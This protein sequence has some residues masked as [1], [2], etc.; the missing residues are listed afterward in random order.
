[1]SK[2][3][4]AKYTA[5][6]VD[7]FTPRTAMEEAARCL[8]CIDAPCSKGCPAGTDPGKFIRS[9]RF[10][11]IKGAAET[12]RENNILGGSC[13]RVCPYDRLC[14]EACSRCGIDRPIEIGKLQRFAVEQEKAHKMKIL[15]AP[16]KKKAD[17]VACIGSGPASLACAAK[18]AQA[19][20]QVTIFEA[21]EKAGGVLTYGI[22]P[23]RLPQHVVDFDIKA[24]KDL[25]VKFVFDT[26]VG[27][28]ITVEELKKADFKAIFVG[29]GLWEAKVPEIPGK[30]LKGVTNAIDFLKAARDSKGDFNPGKNVVVIGGGDVAMDCATTAKLLGAENVA[31]Y[32]R[33]TLEEA[34]ANMAEIQYATSLGVTITT[35][36]APAELVGDKNVEFAVFKGRDG[37]SSAKVAADTVVF[38]IGQAPEDMTKIAPVKVADK[39]TIAAN[40]KG[41]TNVAGIFAAGDI[42]NGGKTVVEAVAAGKEAAAEI[43]EY[44]EKKEGVK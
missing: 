44:L 22:T 12:I 9:I 25:G 33:R 29:A 11:N 34:P 6:A 10:R 8:L 3:V 17:K 40:A 16:S 43:I 28:D 37:A 20:Y 35:N 15:A 27:E 1:M 32:Y 38:A 21:A 23:A 19:G 42:V 18:L 36:F 2:V 41:K 24:V 26:K 7:G 31:I 30:D 14:E 5:D 13:A 39:G 4:K